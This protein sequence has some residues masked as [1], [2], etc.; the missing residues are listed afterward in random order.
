M[1]IQLLHFLLIFYFSAMSMTAAL[2]AATA[3]SLNRQSFPEDFLFG[4]ATSA[5]Q[6]QHEVYPIATK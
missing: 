6:V 5:Y 2:Y 1:E 3:A 4:A